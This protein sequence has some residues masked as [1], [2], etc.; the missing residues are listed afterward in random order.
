MRRFWRNSIL[1]AV[2]T[3]VPFGTRVSARELTPTYPRI[4]NYFLTRTIS[5][6]QAAELAR[7]DV[8]ILGLDNQYT[9]PAVFSIMRQKNPDII[10]LAYVLSEEFPS[11]YD[12][13]SDPNYPLVKLRS[14]IADSWWLRD[15]SGAKT[16]FWAG[17]NMLNVT[18]QVSMVNGYRWNTYLAH[19][20]KDSVLSTGLWD[21]VFYDNVFNDV[22]WVNGGNIDTNNDHVAD[23]G[24]SADA[25]WRDGMSTLLR[26]TRQLVGSDAIII[27]NGGG[28]YYPDMNGRLIEQFPSSLDG[29][30]TGAMAKYADVLRRGLS[31]SIV[32]VNRMTANGLPTDYQGMRYG[33]TSTLLENGFFSFDEG[34]VRHA[35]LWQFDEFTAYLGSPIGNARRIWP[36]AAAS[37]ETGVWRRDFA[38]GIVLVNSTD[39]P[40]TVTLGDGYEELRGTPSDVNGGRIVTSVTLA[41]HDG[42]ILRKRQVVLDTGTYENGSLISVFK[43]D[44]T[45]TRSGFFS[46]DPTQPA[47]AALIKQDVN[48]DGETDVIR[49]DAGAITV[50]NAHNQVLGSFRPFGA[51]R[52][53]LSIAVGDVNG[54]RIDDIVVSPL[55]GKNQ[56][57]SFFTY[58]GRRLW[59][60]WRPFKRD[61]TGGPS[62]TLA[63]M[64]GDGRLEVL[65]AAGRG[66]D[67]RVSVFTLRGR[68]VASFLAY[69]RSFKGGVHLAAGDL[70]AD[71]VPEIVTVPARSGGPHVRIFSN[72]YQPV[73][74]FFALAKSYR[75]GL[76]VAITDVDHTGDN[77]IVISTPY[78][79]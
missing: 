56:K 11:G 16:G 36:T 59:A 34:A 6:A 44:G 10:I 51:Y 14:G 78:V 60:S 28:Q 24:S 49:A 17:A 25:A 21:G 29:G 23:L 45:A 38:N 35:A 2:F 39:A 66:A 62:V 12:G 4:A 74:S 42:R 64:N 54:D 67:P 40:R 19:F 18:N 1:I 30:W 75:G 69:A 3:L 76:Q 9:N 20:V 47:G 57:I 41:G 26:T 37:Y 32:V 50:R 71:G 33:L 52:G 27:G 15:A 5:P 46:Y 31:P 63:D 8:V 55:S 65:A 43:G 72:R 7:W 53:A 79:Y 77:R 22:S 13:L 73:G 70:T 68:Q 61:Y 48:H 58:T